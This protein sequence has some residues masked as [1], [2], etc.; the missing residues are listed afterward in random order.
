MP[1]PL[2]RSEFQIPKNGVAG[3]PTRTRDAHGP[4]SADTASYCEKHEDERIKM[5]CFDCNMN[6]CAMC[7]LEDH[8]T[9]NYERI[10]TVVEQLSKYTDDVI[11]QVTSR[12]DCLRGATAHL[13]AEHNKMSGNINAME[14]EV[15]KRSREIKQLV[16]RQES[17]LLR[18]L[19]SLKSAA[20]KKVRSQKDTLH[21]AV[22]EL[23]SFRT[24]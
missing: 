24:S 19:Q 7:C 6:V 23:E 10:Q 4:F 9:H 13:E 18:R 3:L 16:D 1:C 15:K 14:R 11:E 20:E 22:T 8:K 5:H 17:E 12:I 2:C 21:M